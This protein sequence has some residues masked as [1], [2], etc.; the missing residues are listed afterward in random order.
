MEGAANAGA[1]T[2]P[3]P[4]M[5]TNKA[6]EL[7]HY[8]SPKHSDIPCA[9]VYGLSRALPG[10]RPFCH[11]R[12]AGHRPAK[13][14]ARVGAP[15]PHAFA[16]RVSAARPA[17]SMRPSLPAPNVRDDR[18]TP[19]VSGAGCRER[20]TYFRKT[21][22]KYF[23]AGIWTGQTRLILRGKMAGGRRGFHLAGVIRHAFGSSA[24][25]QRRKW[26]APTPVTAPRF[27]SS[28]T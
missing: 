19:L 23:C 1:T 11:R 10:D 12:F 17:T 28:W 20:T 15:G 6:Y 13:L 2:R 18:E 16:I 4:R 3:Q 22:G 24:V 7:V 8:R 26:V 14:D 25:S 9:T 27:D 5:Q 21:E